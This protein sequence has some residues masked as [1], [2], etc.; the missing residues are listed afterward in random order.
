MTLF[1]QNHFTSSLQEVRRTPFLYRPKDL[2]LAHALESFRD[3]LD[4]T[5][6]DPAMIRYLD[7]QANH[8][9]RP[10]ENY[11]RELFER[12]TL[13][14]AHYTEDDIKQVARA[15]TGWQVDSHTGT[16]RI[17]PSQHN[18]GIKVVFG[19]SGHFSGD[20]ILSLTPERPHL[21]QHLVR[22]LWRKFIPHESD[23]REVSRL[24]DAFRASHDQIKPPGRSLFTSTEFW[25]PEHR[26]VLI[27]PPVEILV[28]TVRPFRLPVQDP[29]MLVRT[30]R[31]L[32]QD[33]RDPSNMKGWP[34]GPRRTTI[35]TLLD[36]W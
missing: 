10:T 27:K 11:I 20:D 17:N 25:A 1:W 9:D 33:S 34:G 35:A 32:G 14:E 29:M 30:G 24:I 8:K 12:F 13:G 31:R 23:A 26:G 2:L 3:L 22:K 19:H 18:E 15:F 5:A 16:D 7:T 28:E 36:R 4:G 21:A 6:K